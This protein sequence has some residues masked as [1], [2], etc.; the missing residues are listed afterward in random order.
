MTTETIPPLPDMEA[1]GR[2]TKAQLAAIMP[3]SGF[4]K[5]VAGYEQAEAASGTAV[6]I[7]KDSA[8]TTVWETSGAC[9]LTFTPSGTKTDTCSKLIDITATGETALTITGGNWAF[10]GTMPVWGTAGSVITIC[11][12]FIAGRVDLYVANITTAVS[13]GV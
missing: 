9:T 6:T 13:S 2:E 5:K 3:F 10:E 8:Y 7:T 1:I 4:K 11:A 12:V